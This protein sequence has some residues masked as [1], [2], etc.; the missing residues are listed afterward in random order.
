MRTFRGLT[1][2]G[3]HS[4]TQTNFLGVLKQRFV[5]H[6]LIFDQPREQEGRLEAD[7]LRTNPGFELGCP[8]TLICIHIYLLVLS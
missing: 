6:Q 3:R 1:P 4:D 5:Y 7:P 8:F 2:S